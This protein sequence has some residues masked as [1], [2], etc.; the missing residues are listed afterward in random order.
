VVGRAPR[1]LL[2]ALLVAGLAATALLATALGRL[3]DAAL[4]LTDAGTTSFSLVAQ[5]LL[6]RKWIENWLLWIVVDAVY[7]VMY[8]SQ[9]LH[10]TAAL[11]V[12]FLVLAVLGWRSW[13]KDL[14]AGRKARGRGRRVV[15]IGPECTGKTTLARELAR[16]YGVEWVPEFARTF[17]EA[18]RRPVRFEDV[19][20]IGRGQ[21]AAE[22]RARRD[23]S[24][25]LVLDTDLV[26]T[27]VY[28]RHYYG[29]CPPWIEEAV[30]GRLSDLY[31][32][33][34]TDVP[35]VPEGYLREQPE[36]RE[37]LYARFR[38]TLAELGARVV[39]VRGT[40][41]QRRATAIA[42]IDALLEADGQDASPSP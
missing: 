11:Y 28:S 26:S 15:L 40:W 18:T 4:P 42:A 19:D 7:V 41:E 1:R 30:P 5:L 35:W 12:A 25:L 3:T 13:S 8:V 20:A 34:A 22:D 32:L 24:R 17:V 27:C 31:L 6:T 39:E 10:L 29:D 9:A 38:Q 37:E 23:R 14:A 21:Q 16:R 36:R 33:L 2:A